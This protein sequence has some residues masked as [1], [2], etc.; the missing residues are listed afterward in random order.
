MWKDYLNLVKKVLAVIILLLC[1]CY[2]INKCSEID[3]P[4]KSEHIKIQHDPTKNVW[5]IKDINY[6]TGEVT[7]REYGPP[8][9]TKYISPTGVEDIIYN[10]DL[11]VEDLID[12]ALD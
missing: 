7:Y 12:Y 5:D 3:K 6:S 1:L 8:P 9:P 11:E 10:A 2:G 4:K